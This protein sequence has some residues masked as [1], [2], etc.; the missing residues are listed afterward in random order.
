MRKTILIM[1]MFVAVTSLAAF[2]WKQQAKIQ[3]SADKIAYDA[4]MKEGELSKTAFREYT[5]NVLNKATREIFSGEATFD[6][7]IA[8]IDPTGTRRDLTAALVQARKTRKFSLGRI[9][10]FTNMT[11]AVNVSSNP[12][13]KVIRDGYLVS[14]RD[15]VELTGIMIDILEQCIDIHKAFCAF[16]KL[17]LNQKLTALEESDLLKVWKGK[18]FTARADEV[19]RAFERIGVLQQKYIIKERELKNHLKQWDTSCR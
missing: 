15:Y 11:S 1:S 6:R 9:D 4:F 12:K 10:V 14:Y 8:Q 3:K 19:D 13:A 7:L 5:A 2:P 18:T 17:R 16:Q